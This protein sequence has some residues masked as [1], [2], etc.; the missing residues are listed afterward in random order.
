MHYTYYKKKYTKCHH[1]SLHY[2]TCHIK[3]GHTVTET[4][5][6]CTRLFCLNCCGYSESH[7]LGHCDDTS[8]KQSK[9]IQRQKL[10]SAKESVHRPKLDVAFTVKSL[11]ACLG[12]VVVACCG[13]LLLSRVS[14]RSKLKY[15]RQ[16][17][18]SGQR[19][20]SLSQ[21]VAF[22]PVQSSLRALKV[23][24]PKAKTWLW[25]KSQFTVT[26]CSDFLPVQSSLRALQVKIPKAKTWLWPKSQFTV[27]VCS[28]FTSTVESPLGC[29]LT[30]TRDVT[31]DFETL[32]AFHPRGGRDTST[33]NKKKKKKKPWRGRRRR[34][35]T[36][37]WLTVL[38][39]WNNTFHFSQERRRTETRLY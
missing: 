4:R 16:K 32:E 8:R 9:I 20:S 35:E 37:L 13:L 14:A 33:S 1:Q 29:Q 30:E 7:C 3:R 38:V 15:P 31:R 34:P 6:L 18:D 22:L 11:R 36:R 26:V 19:V 23:K 39:F 25:P 2:I 27:T 24:I 5:R 12:S 21:Y 17:L 10:D 28:F